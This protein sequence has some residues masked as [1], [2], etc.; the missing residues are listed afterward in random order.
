MPLDVSHVLNELRSNPLEFMRHYKIMIA[1]GTENGASGV[2]TFYFEDKLMTATGFTTGRSGAKGKTKERPIIKFYHRSPTQPAPDAAQGLFNAHYCSMHTDGPMAALGA[3]HHPLPCG[4][5]TDNANPD[6]M[7][8]SQLSNCTFGV[9][10]PSAGTQL[11]T[12]MQPNLGGGHD[13]N[14]LHA[15]VTGGFANGVDAIFERENQGA[16]TGYGNL[17]NRSTIVGVRSGG[18]WH[19]YSQS[20]QGGGA[21]GDLLQAQQLT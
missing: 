11:V 5:V 10:T 4:G 21:G 14:H 19:F 16:N 1:G 12:H 17:A 2:A 8:T 18:Q 15:T 3:T 6:I 20:Y 9:G 7:L 13:R